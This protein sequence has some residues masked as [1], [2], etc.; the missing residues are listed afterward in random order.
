VQ[1]PTECLGIRP[2]ERE[3]ALFM[4]GYD[5]RYKRGHESE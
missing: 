3:A 4:W 2:R 1:R 5:I